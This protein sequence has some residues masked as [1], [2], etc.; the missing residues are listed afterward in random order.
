MGKYFTNVTICH[1][2]RCRSDVYLVLIYDSNSL[3]CNVG[4]K[5]STPIKSAGVFLDVLGCRWEF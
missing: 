2:I 3:E 1:R 4:G 5:K